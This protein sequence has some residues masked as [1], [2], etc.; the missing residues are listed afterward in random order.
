MFILVL[1]VSANKPELSVTV[2][3]TGIRTFVAAVTEVSELHLILQY[4]GIDLPAILNQLLPSQSKIADSPAHMIRFAAPSIVS[5]ELPST[6]INLVQA[7]E[8]RIPISL[9]VL[10][11]AAGSVTV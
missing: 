9:P 11:D 6:V 10:P 2:A 1:D 3:F 5:V 8:M 7:V 4:I